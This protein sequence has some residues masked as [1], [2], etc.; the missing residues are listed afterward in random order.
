M[1]S[2]ASFKNTLLHVPK[3]LD[4]LLQPVKASTRS[5]DTIVQAMCEGRQVRLDD[6]FYRGI[7][8]LHALEKRIGA[9]E[10]RAT[11]REKTAHTQRIRKIAERLWVGYSNHR[12]SIDGVELQS[13][14]CTLPKK[15]GWFYLIRG[16]SRNGWCS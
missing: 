13:L 15:C 9:P 5:T 2:G 4:Q 16:D 1:A 11:F 7:E 10:P 8:I 12:L 6:S 14:L 3:R